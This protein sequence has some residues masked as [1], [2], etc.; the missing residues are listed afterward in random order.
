MTV[1]DDV[2][3][4]ERM[5]TVN[6]VAEWINVSRR[7]V[8][9]YIKKGWIT[10]VKYDHLVRIKRTDVERFLKEHEQKPV[11]SQGETEAVD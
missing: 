6:E 9:R 5:L 11:R 4:E 2:Q 10:A 8:E 1:R 7:T 3:K